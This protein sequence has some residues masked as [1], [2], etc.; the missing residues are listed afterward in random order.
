MAFQRPQVTGLGDK[1]PFLVLQHY[2]IP[3]SLSN[4][5]YKTYSWRKTPLILPFYNVGFIKLFSE[6][7]LQKCHLKWPFKSLKS[8]D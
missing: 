8:L 4:I 6:V 5:I 1:H 7:I 2:S 3:R